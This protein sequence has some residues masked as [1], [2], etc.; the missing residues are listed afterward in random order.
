MK[1]VGHDEIV[2]KFIFQASDS[3]CDGTKTH[4]SSLPDVLELLFCRSYGGADGIG[5][6][7]GTA[8]IGICIFVPGGGCGCDCKLFVGGRGGLEFMRI[9]SN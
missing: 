8:D 5:M 2:H 6:D 4:P 9:N 3:A 7:T 1:C